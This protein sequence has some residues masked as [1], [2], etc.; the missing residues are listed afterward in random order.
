MMKRVYFCE[1]SLEGIFS[2]VYDAW[3]DRNGHANNEIRI[4]T[5]EDQG[6][7][8]L[9]TEYLYI[10][11]SDEKISKVVRAVCGKISEE[12]YELVCGASCSCELSRGDDIYRFLII[13]FSMGKGVVDCLYNKDVMRIFELNRNVSNEAHHYKGFLRFQ[14]MEDGILV[15]R[16][17]P[18]NDII[19]L[20][21]PHFSDRLNQ[22]NFV[23]Y[24]ENRNTA[25]IHQKA[26]RWFYTGGEILNLEKIKKITEKEESI[27]SMWKAFFSSVSIKERENKG[28]QRNNLP[29]RFRSNMSEFKL[30]G[31]E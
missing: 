27:D 2:A 24:D 23:I 22:E 12:A 10:R 6:D 17:K 31:Q 15:G 20:L 13:G 26:E 29:L 4:L 1:D 30:P 8:E 18:K 16:I 14:E 19:R 3:S 11:N 5:G 25:I 7:M 9:F 28:L 21:A